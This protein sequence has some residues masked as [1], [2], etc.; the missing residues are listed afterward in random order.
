MKWNFEKNQD[1][2]QTR[3]T[4]IV[5]NDESTY[6][7]AFNPISC[8]PNGLDAHYSKD[9]KYIEGGYWEEGVL[10]TAFNEEEYNAEQNQ[11]YLSS[12]TARNKW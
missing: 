11:Q 7:G 8:Q 5:P 9:G 2:A 4:C 3:A 12:L 1:Y 10:A 6:V